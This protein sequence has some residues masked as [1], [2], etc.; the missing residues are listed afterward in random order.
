MAALANEATQVE[1]LTLKAP[2]YA[3]ASLGEREIESY[4]RPATR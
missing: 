4:A 2:E 3:G 1:R